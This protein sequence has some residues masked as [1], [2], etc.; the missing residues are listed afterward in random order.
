MEGIVEDRDEFYSLTAAERKGG[1]R[2]APLL[3]RVSL[4]LDSLLALMGRR[5]LE[6]CATTLLPTGKA[7]C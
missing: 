1:T 7:I 5:A 4:R 6:Y 3:R 2:I